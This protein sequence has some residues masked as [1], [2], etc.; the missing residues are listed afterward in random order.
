MRDRADG[1]VLE[2]IRR[3]EMS[4]AQSVQR[5]EEIPTRYLGEPCRHGCAR[6][7]TV[8]DLLTH[9]IEHERMHTGQVVGT[10]DVL[11]CL[12]QDPKDRLVASFYLARAALIASLFGLGD[13]DLDRVPK[14]GEWSIRETIEHV[15][16]WDRDSIDDLAAQ[17]AEASM[18]VLAAPEGCDDGV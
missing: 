9:N 14:E 2:L 18:G 16:Y 13:E 12:Q 1:E 5:L 4:L 11:R 3:L 15:L 17:Y 7:G 10:R 6:G 8:W